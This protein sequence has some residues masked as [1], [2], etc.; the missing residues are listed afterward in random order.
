M[1]RITH[2][3]TDVL[4]IGAGAAGLAAARELSHAGVRAIVIEARRR[5]GGRI[6]TVRDSGSPYPIEL[7]AEF[8]HG[9]VDDTFAIVRAARLLVDEIPDD[10]YHS[11]DGKLTIVADFWEKVEEVGQALAR[12]ARRR[13]GR[14]L[15]FADALDRLRV[16]SDLRQLVLDFVRGYHAA[17]PDRISAR[18]MAA[19]AE[20]GNDA[21]LNR[22]FRVTRGQDGILEWLRHGL[23]PERVE[24]R[25]NTIATVL[26]WR[27]GEVTLRC[28]AGS[29]GEL[30]PFRARAAIVALPHAVLRGGGLELRPE[31]T[32]KQRALEQL[33]AGQVF[34]IGFRFRESFWEPENFVRQRLEKARPEPP[35]LNFVHG[36]HSAVPTWWTAVPVRAPILT[37]WAGGPK[38]EALLDQDELT[39]VDRSLTALAEVLAVPRSMLDDLVEGWWTHDWRADPFSRGAYTYPKVGGI[40]AQDILAR[41]VDGTLFF[42][43]EATD[44]EQTGTVAGAI[45][46]GRRAARQ[47]IRMLGP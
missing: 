15:S 47:V 21:S 38:A 11:R 3:P 39:R 9:E 18:F 42:A 16:P 1:K 10:H 28:L 32:D 41:P 13:P 37:G 46:S 43:G 45:G 6:Y 20:S 35:A 40:R 23:D 2:K 44:S 33:E 12:L 34:K 19:G 5:V 8:I 30:A 4:V 22:Q 25:L 36:S 27:R 17:D 7:G 26:A 14:D 24:L 31:L 29:G